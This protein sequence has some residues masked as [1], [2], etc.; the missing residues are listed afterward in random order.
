MSTTTRTDGMTATLL[1]RG[2]VF[3]AGLGN[4]PSLADDQ[5]HHLFLA[6]SL[7]LRPIVTLLIVL[8]DPV[9]PK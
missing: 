9:K 6:L 4:I 7:L 5:I 2:I 8:L 1:V 3:G